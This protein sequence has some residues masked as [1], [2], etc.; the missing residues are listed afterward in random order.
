MLIGAY[1]R[2]F[3]FKTIGFK[4][5]VTVFFKHKAEVIAP[6]QFQY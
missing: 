6:K 4:K 1:G 5:L 2:G 3:I